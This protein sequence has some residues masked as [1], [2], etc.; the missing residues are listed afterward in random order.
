V[1]LFHLPSENALVVLGVAL[2]VIYAFM[3]VRVIRRYPQDA[4]LL[5]S[6]RL[7]KRINLFLTT[8]VVVAAVLVPMPYK[9]L[10][11][12][13]GVPLLVYASWAHHKEL[14]RSGV[15]AAF[16][17]EMAVTYPV[18]AAGCATFVATTLA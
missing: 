9:A 14:A 5:R 6:S 2:L 17:R 12:V 1:T 4:A 10:V 8:P 7:G 13:V 18:A 15:S 3:F 11:L 16:L